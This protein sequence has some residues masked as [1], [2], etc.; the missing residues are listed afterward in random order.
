MATLITLSS[1][2][3]TAPIA[4]LLFVAGFVITTGWIGKKLRSNTTIKGKPIDRLYTF[5]Y[6]GNLY[7]HQP[8]EVWTLYSIQAAPDH[9]E[10]VSTC[11]LTDRELDN[12]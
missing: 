10:L 2:W 1:L 11:L 8:L 4:Q 12:G 3:E 9:L 7:K 5:K 6:R